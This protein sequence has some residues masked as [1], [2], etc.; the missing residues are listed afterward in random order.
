MVVRSESNLKSLKDVINAA[1]ER[2]GDLTC[3]TQGIQV[4]AYFDYQMICS[5]FGVKITHVPNPNASD[6]VANVMG[7]HVDF[8]LGS[9]PGLLPLA[10]GGRLRIL[11]F[12]G[13]RRLP[14]YPDMPTFA[15][16]G[17]PRANM[18]LHAGIWGPKDMPQEVFS[19]W[20]NA[21]R[22]SLANPEIQAA[23]KKNNMYVDLE[24]DRDKINKHIKDQFEEALQIAKKEG[25]QVK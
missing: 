10:K 14:D 8:W 17:V 19:V 13:D 16:Q 21:L 11:A 12:T 23:C 25:I 1:K 22:A 6:A 4:E 2:P 18:D 7:G 20:Q 3:A 9:L 24:T 15:E 5:T